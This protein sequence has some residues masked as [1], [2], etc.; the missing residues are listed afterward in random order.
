MTL[1][2]MTPP[3][4]RLRALTPRQLEVALLIAEDFTVKQIATKLA[5]TVFTV[6]NHVDHIVH[7]WDLDPTRDAKTQIAKR[8]LGL[9]SRPRAS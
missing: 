9:V 5:V 2:A 1:A 3:A 8:V 4:D 7:V 6:H